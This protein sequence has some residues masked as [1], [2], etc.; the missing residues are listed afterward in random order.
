MASDYH[1][2]SFDDI[3]EDG[4]LWAVRYVCDEDNILDTLFAQWDDVQWLR[5][6]FKENIT[7]LQNYFLISDVD[8]AVDITAEDSD[9]LQRKILDISPDANIDYL[10]EIK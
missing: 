9:V 3:T 4:R 6:F 8:V 2:A 1:I 7:D 5:H 10:T